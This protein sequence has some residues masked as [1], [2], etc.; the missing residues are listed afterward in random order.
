MINQ[1]KF[2]CTLFVILLM[3]CSSSRVPPIPSP[4]PTAI[5]TPASVEKPELASYFQD[6]TGAFVLHNQNDNQTTR[7]NV[8]R[9]AERLL[10]ASTFKILNALI[11][12]ETN[13][14]P[15]ENYVIHWDGKQYP[16]TSWNQDQT[17]KTAMQNSVVWYY[18]ELARRVGREQM[19]KYVTA[20]GYGNQEISGP[21]DSFWLNGGLRIST[22]DQIVFL[23]RLYQNDLP[24]SG[25][26]MQIVREIILLD[27][28]R[29]YWLSGK[30]G[31]GQMDNTNIGW[32]VGY[33]EAKDNVYFFATNIASDSQ[34]TP[35]AKAKE[36]SLKI[37]QG[38]GLLP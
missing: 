7:Y 20:A 32:F 33:L 36:I 15:D 2:G 19:Q 30:T 21:I 1:L 17:L 27:K 25:R 13:V 28:T 29:S 31:S 34:A 12:L 22:D 9:C 14:I 6:F 37:L 4:T 18:Q 26:S 23:K 3:G 10:P 5:P 11:G 8:Q 38:M 16:T 35:A 24:F